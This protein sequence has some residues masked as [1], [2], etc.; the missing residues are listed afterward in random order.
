MDSR[1]ESTALPSS[2]AS[3]SNPPT[4]SATSSPAKDSAARR[5]CSKCSRKMSSCA[6][7]KHLICLNCRDVNCSVDVRCKECSS[8]STEAMLEY[9]KHQKSLVS[10]GRKRSSVATPTSTPPSVSPS[11]APVQDSVSLSQVVPPVSS[12]PSLASE[13]GLKSLV[14]SVLVSFLSQPN[15]SLGSNP[16]VAAPS[17][18]VPNVSNI[19]SAGGSEDDNL[20]RGRPVAPSGMVPLPIQ[21]DSLPSM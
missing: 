1:K 13:E 3:A 20:M 2:S 14:Q 10:K 12:I 9:V 4:L 21:E 7:D 18:E 11:A 5:S 6:N 15:L 8:W 17:A 19:G 16:F